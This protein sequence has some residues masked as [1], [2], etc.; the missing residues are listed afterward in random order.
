MI[1]KTKLIIG[2]GSTFG[3]QGAV[4]PFLI[5]QDKGVTTV[6]LAGSGSLF[7]LFEQ[8]SNHKQ[9]ISTLG[10]N[11]DF[12]KIF[13]NVLPTGSA[14]GKESLENKEIEMS[15]T[16]A[17]DK[18]N[19]FGHASDNI[20]QNMKN[21]I[22]SHPEKYL[23]GQ[24]SRKWLLGNDPIF[25]FALDNVGDCF[26]KNL[27]SNNGGGHSSHSNSNS[28]AARYITEILQIF[29]N[30]ESAQKEASNKGTSVISSVLNWFRGGATKTEKMHCF[31]EWI[32]FSREGGLQ[33]SNLNKVILNYKEN[34]KFDH[35]RIREI[36]E[37]NYLAFEFLK[38]EGLQ[39]TLFAIPHSFYLMNKKYLDSLGFKNTS[40]RST[41]SRAFRFEI[42]KENVTNNEENVK[43][44]YI[45][46]LLVNY[47]DVGKQFK[48]E[49]TYGYDVNKVF[50]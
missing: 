27:S 46:E 29:T 25:F 43:K 36:P 32:G 37:N 23:Y 2:W 9:G 3:S 28:W 45:F 14:W 19:I 26:K 49:N 8:L 41:K 21:I 7:D 35:T 13:L 24:R 38:R 40:L 6:T 12:D 5:S 22:F 48:W 17:E 47:L 33:R 18:E 50:N 4:I 10:K 31:E 44:A 20:F 15:L 34:E 39:N 16:S 11:I 1:S 30:R 42:S